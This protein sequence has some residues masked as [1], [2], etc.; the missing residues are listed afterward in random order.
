MY[1]SLLKKMTTTIVKNNKKRKK[2]MMV[3]MRTVMMI[4]EVYFYSEV[5]S[6]SKKSTLGTPG[7]WG[8]LLNGFSRCSWF[9]NSSLIRFYFTFNTLFLIY[10]TLRWCLT[11]CFMKMWS[12]SP[13][14][15]NCFYMSHS[16]S[17]DWSIKK[18]QTFRYK[19]RS[20]SWCYFA[21]YVSS[22]RSIFGIFPRCL[23]S[24][25][26]W[27]GWLSVLWMGF[28][29]CLLLLCSSSPS[30]GLLFWPTPRK[31]CWS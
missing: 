17:I 16:L 27:F 11:S 6:G 10:L 2:K 19:L 25:I 29:S 18:C 24:S 31:V 21:E 20:F 12:M 23:G 22:K 3:I 28:H 4:E 1:T 26:E 14:G 5:L 15:R 9:L 30:R 7:I 8:N 13:D